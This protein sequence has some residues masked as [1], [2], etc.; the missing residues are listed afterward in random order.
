MRLY[1]YVFACYGA[2]FSIVCSFHAQGRVR[3]TGTAF[4]IRTHPADR[5]PVGSQ[6]SGSRQRVLRFDL[7]L[8]FC[9]RIIVRIRIRKRLIGD[10]GPVQSVIADDRHTV[11]VKQV[12][13]DAGSYRGGR[14]SAAQRQTAHYI[15]RV[16]LVVSFQPH[17]I[18]R[19]QGRLI[20]YQ[21]QA[22]AVAVLQVQGTG[23]TAAVC[24]SAAVVDC[25]ILYGRIA[26]NV[27][28]SRCGSIAGSLP[29]FHRYIFT[30]KN[31]TVSGN[32]LPGN[33]YANPVAIG[34]R[35]G[36]VFPA[37]ARS[38]DHIRLCFRLDVNILARRKRRVL[39]DRDNTPVFQR[40]IIHGSGYV[41]FAVVIGFSVHGIAANIVVGIGSR[42]EIIGKGS[43]QFFQVVIGF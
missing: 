10:F 14:F 33:A 20:I 24:L 34:F 29:G 31:D 15:D 22:V 37:V 16:Q 41:G 35:I 27:N 23:Q 2:F 19:L 36:Q 5:R 25:N 32:V 30:G 18:C 12:Q 3:L 39:S 17:I 11:H 28:V 4:V 42:A 26:G 40:G 6:F 38:A 1:R 43:R 9:A 13:G 21:Y 7:V 8:F